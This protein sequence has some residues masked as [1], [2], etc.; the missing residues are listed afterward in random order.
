MNRTLRLGL[1]VGSTTVKAVVLDNQTVVFADYRRHNADVRG[2][3]RRL[4][5]DISDACPGDALEVAMTGSGGLSVAKIM[6]VPFIQEVVASTTAIERFY[7]QADVVIELGGEDAKL[8]YLHPIPEQRMNGTCAG[9]TGAF[10]DQMAT[11]LK[12]DAAGLDDLA[13]RYTSLYP[14]ASRCGVFAKSD[15]QPLLNQG[16]AHEDIAA[17]VFQ[18]VATQTIAGLACGHPIRGN[19][20]FLGGPLHFLPQL[21]EAFRRALG[22]NVDDYIT[23]KDAQLFVALGAAISTT[24][25]ALSL[26]HI[27]ANLAAAEG[28][29]FVTKTMRPLFLSQDERAEFNARHGSEVIA[30]ASLDDAKGGL[31]LGLDAGSTTIKSVVMDAEERILFSTYGSNEGDPI[32]SAV[33]IARQIR[34]ALPPNAW[35]ARACV[36]G[37]GETLVQAALHADE[38][39]IETMAHYRAAKKLTPDVTSVIDIGGQDMKFLKIRN[40]AVDSIAVNEACSSGCGSFLQTFAATMD[41]DIATFAAAGL[42][43]DAPVDLGSR[44]TVFMNSSVKQAQKEGAGLADISAG[45]SYSVVRNALY[46]VMKLRDSGDLGQV[47][48][49]QGGTFLNDAV[50]RAF[51]LLTGVQV[52][53]PNIAG[54]MGAYGA[55]LTA[56]MHAADNISAVSPFMTRDL[57]AFHVESEQRTCQICANHCKLTITTFDDGA[58]NV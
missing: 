44:C 14:I 26:P 1:D 19:V 27:A 3:L 45:L 16:A 2:E 43:S 53:R 4:L 25:P 31:Y 55:A 36:T 52:V 47:V 5:L 9:G 11:L 37:Y 33:A 41:T 12:T 42:T 40:G 15:V 56:K 17:S 32:A 20:I 50:L 18:A 38:G 58:R 24:A 13:A 10:I 21:R 23:P 48:V 49:A 57:D 8:T 51:E 46:K 39:E 6:G 28:S 30:Q 54:L 7:P 22:D 29:V 35:I 34:A